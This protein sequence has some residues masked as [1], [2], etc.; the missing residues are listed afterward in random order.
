METT[1]HNAIAELVRKAEND[2]VFGN[3]M[4]SR[5]VQINQYETLNTIDAYYNSKH[6]SGDTDTQGREK[7]FF[8]I[9]IAAVNI[10]YRATDID[11]K[12]IKIIPTKSED[13]I[14]ACLAT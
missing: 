3:T 10:W 9:V 4:L 8:N 14:A 5:Y 6:T 13:D 7:P 12:N 1:E 2:Y 11:R